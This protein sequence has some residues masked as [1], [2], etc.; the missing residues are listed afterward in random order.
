MYGFVRSISGADDILRIKDT[1]PT[2][3][4]VIWRDRIQMV[5]DN[6]FENV[7]AFTSEIASVIPRNDFIAKP[8]PFR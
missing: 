6:W 4:D 7:I 2:I 3:R 5:D 1:D 8:A